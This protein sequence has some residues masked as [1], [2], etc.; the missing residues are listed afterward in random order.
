LMTNFSNTDTG[1]QTAIPVSQNFSYLLISTIIFSLITY[2]G[3]LITFVTEESSDQTL[4]V[5]S[6]GFTITILTCVGYFI[7][8]IFNITATDSL[9]AFKS[10]TEVKKQIVIG[11]WLIFGTLTSLQIAQIRT[12]GSNYSIVVLLYIFA[13]LNYFFVLCTF[14][15]VDLSEREERLTK[16]LFILIL[17]FTLAFNI[18]GESDCTCF[19][20]D[21][22]GTAVRLFDCLLSLYLVVLTVIFPYES[23]PIREK[24][25]SLREL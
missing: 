10:V 5:G 25:R 3:Q 4:K 7:L 16:I 9:V 2:V 6:F 23:G 21:K 8:F 11:F 19:R 13:Y 1:T 17:T 15:L 24:Y 18:I 22:I 20:N 12:S 14:S